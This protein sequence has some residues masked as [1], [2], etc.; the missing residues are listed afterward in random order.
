M[1]EVCVL[2]A[3]STNAG[4]HLAFGITEPPNP[5]IQYFG[6]MAFRL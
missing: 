4:L 6:D 5:L 1:Y 2:D 3:D